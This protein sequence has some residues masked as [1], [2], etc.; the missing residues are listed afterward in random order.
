MRKALLALTI[1]ATGLI[2][3]PA[4][5]SAAEPGEVP[6]VWTCTTVKENTGLKGAVTATGCAGPEGHYAPA[7]IITTSAGDWHCLSAM[8]EKTG[9]RVT[10][11]AL[12]CKTL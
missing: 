9:E 12:G 3:H 11:G 2:A 6:G 8:G 7:R 10:V 4:I 1:A 5:A